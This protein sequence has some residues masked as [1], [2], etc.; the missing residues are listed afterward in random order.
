MA[1]GG[2]L[3]RYRFCVLRRHLEVQIYQVG[4]VR[5]SFPVFHKKTEPRYQGS[6]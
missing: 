4:P 1:W 2:E 5:Y 6:A 3:K